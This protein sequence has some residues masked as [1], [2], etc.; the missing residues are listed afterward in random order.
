MA[1]DMYNLTAGG[2]AKLEF[3]RTDRRQNSNPRAQTGGKTQIL[4]HKQAAKDELLRPGADM[5]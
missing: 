5:I 1:E 2:T 3:S 4:E